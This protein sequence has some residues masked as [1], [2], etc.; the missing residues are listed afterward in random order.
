MI[1]PIVAVV[2]SAISLCAISWAIFTWV[3]QS[4]RNAITSHIN[5]LCDLYEQTDHQV[6]LNCHG[7]DPEEME[8]V[9]IS[10]ETL[11]YLLRNFSIARMYQ[12]N[13]VSKQEG[14]FRPGSYRYNLC[15]SED[16]RDAF[17]LLRRILGDVE[18]TRRIEA[19]LEHIKNNGTSSGCHEPATGGESEPDSRLETQS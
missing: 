4:R 5:A 15:S 14:S 1:A 10:P 16:T 13:R 11:V 9:G 19:T 6:L 8:E 17:P 3:K 7:I 12:Y 2:G 18:I